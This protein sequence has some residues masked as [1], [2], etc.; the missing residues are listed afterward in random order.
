MT[1][2]M[3]SLLIDIFENELGPEAVE[4]GRE[5]IAAFR[6]GTLDWFRVSLLMWALS[7]RHSVSLPQLNEC[8]DGYF[9]LLHGVKAPVGLSGANLTND[10]SVF[11]YVV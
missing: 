11:V 7:T 10:E 9:S 3:I 2:G 4:E 1:S 8:A 5:K 6:D